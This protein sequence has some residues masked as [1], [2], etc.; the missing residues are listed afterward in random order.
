MNRTVFGVLTAIF[1][2][3]MMLMLPF[4]SVH[5]ASVQGSGAI[6]KVDSTASPDTTYTSGTNADLTI[7]VKNYNGALAS[8]LSGTTFVYLYDSSGEL[9]F[10]MTN[11]NSQV[12]FYNLQESWGSGTPYYIYVLHQPNEGLNFMEFWGGMEVKAYSSWDNGYQANPYTFVRDMPIQYGTSAS[13]SQNQVT[14]SVKIYNPDTSSS[15][16]AFANVYLSTSQA[17]SVSQT[18][19]QAGGSSY[20]PE[21]S[22]IT[23]T[24]VF[25]NV[26]AANYNIYVSIESSYSYDLSAIYVSN[27]TNTDQITWNAYHQI[28]VL[29]SEEQVNFNPTTNG[30]ISWSYP[31]YAGY[32][33]GTGTVPASGGSVQVPQGVSLTLTGTGNPGYGFSQWSGG[34]FSGTSSSETQTIN[35]PITVGASFAQQSTTLS[36]S[37][38]SGGSVNY[39]YESGGITHTGKISSGGYYPLSVPAGTAVSLSAN[40]QSGYGFTGWTGVS[41]SAQNPISIT[42]NSDESVQADFSQ[43]FSVSVSPGSESIQTGQSVNFNA[44]T[45]GGSGG[46]TYTWYQDGAIVQEG[47]LS[48]YSATFST[49]GTYSVYVYVSDSDGNHAQ[50]STDSIKVENP[51]L[52]VSIQPGSETISAGNSVTFTSSISGGSGTYSYTWNIDGSPVGSSSQLT[53]TFSSQGTY[54]ISL[55]VEDSTGSSAMSTV[56]TITV[57]S[58]TP[59]SVTVSSSATSIYSGNSLTFTANPSGG[60]SPYSFTWYVNGVQQSGETG[61]SFTYDFSTSGTYTVYSSV[62]DSVGTAA[63]SN[64]VSVTAASS[65]GSIVIDVTGL[66]NSPL[67]GAEVTLSTS[68]SFSSVYAHLQTDLA[69]QASFSKIPVG[70]YYVEVTDANYNQYTT[71]LAVSPGTQTSKSIQL[72]PVSYSVTIESGTGGTVSYTTQSNSGTVQSGSLTDL[73]IP[74]GGSLALM[75]SNSSAYLFQ[76]WTG[77]GSGTSNSYTLVVTSSGTVTADFAIKTFQV[78]FTESGIIDGNHWSVNLNGDNVTATSP[79][80]ITFSGLSSGA[81]SFTAYSD[82]YSVTSSQSF[83]VTSNGE[84]TVSFT[85]LYSVVETGYTVT[86]PGNLPRDGST[87]TVSITMENL[88]SSSFSMP[89]VLPSYLTIPNQPGGGEIYHQVTPVL[90]QTLTLAP[91]SKQTF[92]YQTNVNWN[93][94]VP[95][96][97]SKFLASVLEGLAINIINNVIKEGN[98]AFMDYAKKN[99]FDNGLSEAWPSVD[100]MLSNVAEWAK[101]ALED[102]DSMMGF[103]DLA[104]NINSLVI[105]DN[106]SMSLPAGVHMENA[107][108]TTI[109]APQNKIAL[110]F[111]DVAAY[112]AANYASQILQVAAEATLP[113]AATVAGA[114]IPGILTALSILV[115][116]VTEAIMQKELSDPSLNYTQ[117]VNITPPPHSIT[118]IE[119]SLLEEIAIHMYYYNAYINASAESNTRGYEAALKNSTQFE[120]LQDSYALKYAKLAQQNYI[121]MKNE[122]IALLA[123]LNRT[124]NLDITNFNLGANDTSNSTV[125]GNV[126]SVVSTLNMGSYFNESY[127]NNVSY[128]PYNNSVQENLSSNLVDVGT[129]IQN[130]SQTIMNDS[131]YQ[132]LPS[133]SMDVFVE[134]GLPHGQSWE[135][136]VGGTTFTSIN[137]TIQARVPSGLNSYLAYSGLNYSVTNGDVTGS[138]SNVSFVEVDFT[139]VPLYPVTFRPEGIGNGTWSLGV[140]NSLQGI[141]EFNGSGSFTIDLPNGSYQ[142]YVVS[143]QGYTH[144]SST[145]SF[146]VQGNSTVIIVN[147]EPTGLQLILHY[148]PLILVILIAASIGIV[149]YT[150]IKRR[151]RG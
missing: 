64:T 132:I 117:F 45:S 27:P 31:A 82:Y 120:Y 90:G 20:I 112:L 79:D 128:Q 89:Q 69:G 96:K 142:Y 116:P 125:M 86:P 68:S 110:T 95:E 22:V 77:L 103:L 56:S 129:Y 24:V 73:S 150:A 30:Q 146:S 108:N 81:H 35:G 26:A 21:G 107:L 83:T 57:G 100:F 18:L 104:S 39:Q 133:T 5:F 85:P 137:S 143:P 119:N 59:L 94:A 151:R 46:Y 93:V 138:S 139:T 38:G 136:L 113:L 62:T 11:S 74:Y 49:S 52:S 92:T 60:T 9:T 105:S 106:L 42:V 14:V 12:N 47:T 134:S 122:S 121:Q 114:A 126:M 102:S 54:S 70:T 65:Y 36:I 3:T 84:V 141:R 44:Y 58:S 97:A 72:Q 17:T 144:N 149:S 111:D 15:F 37:S 23:D 8:S 115:K 43:G 32:S 87:F 80:S 41:V 123:S 78:S 55:T 1:I 16:Y 28:T 145:D 13:V 88:G 48:S 34:T 63:Q 75:E 6:A 147:F 2:T 71:S 10:E 61:S 98:S 25:S 4:S 51:Q 127:F 91:G 118:N 66:Q 101:S 109:Y 76:K 19:H 140:A 29:G 67:S 130:N 53:H 148:V 99:F 7:T 124:G 40:P 50:S 135:I 33:A 131:S